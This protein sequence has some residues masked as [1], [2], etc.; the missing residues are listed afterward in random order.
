M[1]AFVALNLIRQRRRTDD[2]PICNNMPN[3]NR[4]VTIHIHRHSSVRIFQTWSQTR[5]AIITNICVCFGNYTCSICNKA[6]IKIVSVFYGLSASILTGLNQAHCAVIFAM[7]N[8]SHDVARSKGA[9]QFCHLAKTPNRQTQKS[10]QKAHNNTQNKQYII[11][12]KICDWTF[13]T[14]KTS[15]TLSQ[16]ASVNCAEH[17]QVHTTFWAA[18]IIVKITRMRVLCRAYETWSWFVVSVF[19]C[20]SESQWRYDSE[21]VFGLF[22]IYAIPR[23][24][25]WNWKDLE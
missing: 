17:K 5:W 25:L 19:E 8:A 23:G 21:E 9:I 11:I 3:Q 16:R 7:H 10:H 18:R 24:F 20:G 22:S 6:I 14:R 12:I 1:R 4:T 2:M 15:I 13:N